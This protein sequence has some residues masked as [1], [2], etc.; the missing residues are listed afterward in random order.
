[1]A[2]TEPTPVRRPPVA[3]D[4][5][6]LLRLPTVLQ[7]TGLKKTTLY[8]LIRRNGFPRPVQLTDRLVAWRSAEIEVWAKARETK[9]T[10]I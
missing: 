3:A 6:A 10:G 8:G 4:A 7:L 2:G 9:Q 5:Y 1:M